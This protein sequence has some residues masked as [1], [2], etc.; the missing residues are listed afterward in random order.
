MDKTRRLS[1]IF[2]KDGRALIVA[3]DHGTYN[4]AS[5]GIEDMGEAIRRIVEGGADAAI[6]NMGVARKYAAEL[7]EIGLIA[8]LDIPPTYLAEGHHSTAVFEADYALKLGA[9]AVIINGGIGSNVEER[10][11]PAIAKVVSY[12][13]SIGMPVCGEVLPGGFDADFGL[14]TVENIAR[15]NRIVNELGVD[16]I[17]SA[18]APGYEK[19]IGE[20]FCPIVIL[21]GPKTN[22]QKE[23][24]ANIKKALEEGVSGVAMGRNIWGA[25]D[26]VRM[27]R[28]L[29]ALIHHNATVDEAYDI[30]RGV[31][32]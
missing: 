30:L 15:C 18:Y 21:G 6:V 23:Y 7:A 3:I 13:E 28:A 24:L 1:R 29:A 19:V 5:P 4:G 2:K 16:F 22:D 11:L 26:P 14:R 8:R 12:C 10:S 25:E 17:K 20:T 31:K 9:D 27:T 32:A